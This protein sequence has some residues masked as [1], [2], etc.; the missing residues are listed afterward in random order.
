M[1]KIYLHQ[2]TWAEV[3]DYLAKDTVILLPFGSTEQHGL[4]LPLGN[5]ALVAIRLAE[6]AARL[7]KTLVENK[8]E[9]VKA[10]A[11]F[12]NF[13]PEESWKF[14]SFG[15]PLHPGAA[16]YYREKGMMK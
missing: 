6:D 3:K 1:E 13:L 9:L 10:H 11:G 8:N 15:I 12:K 5:D 7:T 16:K 4:H 2:W 14:E